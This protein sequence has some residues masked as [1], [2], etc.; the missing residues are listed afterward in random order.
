MSRHDS[1]AL[2]ERDLERALISEGFTHTYVWQDGPNAHYPAHTHRQDTAHIILAGEMTLTLRGRPRTYRPG[3]R[4][5]VPADTRH[6]AA[7]GPQ[8]CRYLVGER[9]ARPRD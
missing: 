2:E 6:A 5:D 3:E 4:V 1:R 9:P 8:G 7:M